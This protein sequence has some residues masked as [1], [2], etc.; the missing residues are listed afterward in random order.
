VKH[1]EKRELAKYFQVNQQIHEAILEAARNETLATQ[2]RSLAARVRRARY[3]ANM[4]QDRW[5]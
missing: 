2:Y 5:A 3:V 4:T 1:Y